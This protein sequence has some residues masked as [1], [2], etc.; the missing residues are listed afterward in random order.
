[1]PARK[2]VSRLLVKRI[3][4]VKP[5]SSQDFAKET[6]P[7]SI[8]FRERAFF[9]PTGS[10][11]NLVDEEEEEMPSFEMAMRKNTGKII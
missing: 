8:P 7:A 3:L 2:P 4:L 6:I 11:D 10:E 1:M 9:Q 5:K